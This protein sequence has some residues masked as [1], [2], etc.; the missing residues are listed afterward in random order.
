MSDGKSCKSTARS[1]DNHTKNVNAEFNDVD[2][3]SLTVDQITLNNGIQTFSGATGLN[4]IQIP[5]NLA[6]AFSISQGANDY[7]SMNS[8]NSTENVQIH[9]NLYPLA[10]TYLPSGTVSSPALSFNNSSSTGLYRIGDD[11]IGI[12]TAGALT[13]Q[14]K[15]DVVRCYQPLNP[16]SGLFATFIDSDN[17][18][19]FLI[20]K[21]SDGGDVFTVDTVNDTVT[22]NG[23]LTANNYTGN[24]SSKW[25]CQ[26]YN[27]AAQA[28]ANNSFTEVS[29]NTEAY[30]S[31]PSSNMAD[32]A[33]NRITIRETGLY[34]LIGKFFWA[35]ATTT[36]T[37]R[38]G[39]IAVGGTSVARDERSAVSGTASAM[40]VST[41]RQLTTGNHVTLD[42]L[43][44]DGAALNL[45]GTTQELYSSLSV[46]YLG[47]T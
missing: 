44:N 36:D 21:D 13:M 41:V 33:N 34:L 17:T 14:V 9:K 22:I 46:S 35:N 31:S 10:K 7:I 40:T 18:E 1:I 47:S 45:G 19:A 11:D 43:Q 30:D 20:R 16:V 29:M 42:C 28:I 25:N 37:R 39:I 32:L 3:D 4:Q 5:D 15:T 38:V 6:D 23:D 8:S 27:D 2:T 12:S 24:V 26:I